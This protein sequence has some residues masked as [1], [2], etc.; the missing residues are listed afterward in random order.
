MRIV[1]FG[2]WLFLFLMA[3]ESI[4]K[5]FSSERRMGWIILTALVAYAA[6]WFSQRRRT[7]TPEPEGRRTPDHADDM[8][9]LLAR[10]GIP[11][12]AGVSTPEMA[13]A[14]GLVKTQIYQCVK[15]IEA[16]QYLEAAGGMNSALATDGKGLDPKVAG[17]CYFLRSRAHIS[18]GDRDRAGVDLTRAREL[19]P[20]HPLIEEA[21]ALFTSVPAADFYA[22]PLEGTTE[23]GRVEIGAAHE[24][25]LYDYP[26]PE[27]QKSSVKY[28]YTLAVHA[29]GG[30]QPILFVTSEYNK[31]PPE[32]R[33]GSHFLGVF[34]GDGHINLGASD[35]WADRDRF[36]TRAL[37]V[38]RE[39]LAQG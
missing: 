14:G 9:Q 15:R 16:R 26:P 6:L 32:R 28:L 35:D 39:R 25:V 34:A 27:Q 8:A 24:G 12:D 33:S 18:M 13:F 3:E 4:R 1:G 31:M 10:L 11:L 23:S 36:R 7:V 19:F 30:G 22:P 38:A 17:I 21:Y 2:I 20:G 37:E 5:G 29:K